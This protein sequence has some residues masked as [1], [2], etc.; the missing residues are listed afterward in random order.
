MN[1]NAGLN[2]N[3]I[4][5]TFNWYD[6]RDPFCSQNPPGPC[7][8]PGHAARDLMARILNCVLPLPCV[9]GLDPTDLDREIE[10]LPARTRLLQNVPNPF[11]PTT[12]IRFDLAQ[13]GH[14]ELQIFDVAGHRVR[15]LIDGP[16]QARRGHVVVWNGLD[17]RGQ[18]V[19][20]GLY[21]YRLTASDVTAIRKMIVM[22]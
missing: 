18:R 10:A 2:W 14:V 12:T 7:P 16:L 4:L 1:K 3:T 22:K 17:D 13:T 6:I 21:F 9:R 20:S 11:N 5:S 15:E 19:P 8:P